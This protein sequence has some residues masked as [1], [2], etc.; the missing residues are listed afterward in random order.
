MTGNSAVFSLSLLRY[1]HHTFHIS[2]N[3]V[4]CLLQNSPWEVLSFVNGC[5]SCNIIPQQDV[6]SHYPIQKQNNNIQAKPGEQGEGSGGTAASHSH[7]DN[8]TQA[9]VIIFKHWH[10]AWYI[11]WTDWCTMTSESTS[12]L[13]EECSITRFIQSA[14]SMTVHY[15]HHTLPTSMYPLHVSTTFLPFSMLW[16]YYNILLVKMDHNSLKGG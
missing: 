14:M 8:Y 3:L 7:L 2:L 6:V 12:A 11:S 15:L 13:P 1:F 10:F 5:N 4:T 16:D 9:T